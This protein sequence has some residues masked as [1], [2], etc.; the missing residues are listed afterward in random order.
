VAD[1]FSHL[2]YNHRLWNIYLSVDIIPGTKK[3]I[4]SL[5]DFTEFRK[6]EQ[7]LRVSEERSRLLFNSGRDAVAVHKMGKDGQP[8]NFI[9]VNDVAC[10]RLGY[11][12]EE[13]LKLTPQD[14]DA[15]DRSGQMPAIIETLL[16]TQH[17]LFETEHVA[18]DGHRIPVE[19]STV[20]FQ[21]DGSPATM[22]VARDITERKRIEQA[23][24]VSEA[25]Y[26]SVVED[27][28]ELICRFTPKGRLT[29]VN[30]AYCRYFGLDKNACIGCRHR[31][32]IPPEDLPQMMQHLASLT[33]E[34]PVAAIEHRI[35]MSSGEVRWQRWNDRAIFDRDGRI[36]EY[37]SVGRDI[38][39]HKQAE[40]ALSESEERYRTV[41]EHANEA[42]FIIQDG[43]ICY[44]NPKLEEIG[45]FTAEELAQ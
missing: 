6:A 14:I 7:E 18:K 10:E 13:M 15:P 3:S 25:Q 38:T 19:I 16:K 41:I 37:Q 2:D 17:V 9:E 31:V 8:T 33:R 42:I 40:E 21:L 30:D 44:A 20:L 22:S 35:I 12:R 43:R 39:E 45:G 27:Q 4:A 26:R 1:I 11:T 32:V 29:F 5:L 36:I 24:L 28:T 34:N 23:L